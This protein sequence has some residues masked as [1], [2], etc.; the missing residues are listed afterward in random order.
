VIVDQG[1][2]ASKR[3]PITFFG[4][5]VLTD[6]FLSGVVLSVPYLFEVSKGIL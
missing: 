6:F 3:A 5:N 2:C 1:D 4:G